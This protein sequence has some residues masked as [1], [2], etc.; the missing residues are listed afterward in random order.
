MRELPMR[1]A[2]DHR[3]ANQLPTSLFAIATAHHLPRRYFEKPL[4][5]DLC[6]G[7]RQELEFNHPAEISRLDLEIATSE[8]V[9]LLNHCLEPPSGARLK[10]Q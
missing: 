10:T 4:R 8:G 6:A 1:L 5:F 2:K 3:H 9:V 7:C